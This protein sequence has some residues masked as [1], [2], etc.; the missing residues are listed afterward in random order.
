[1]TSSRPC[2]VMRTKLP[3]S[4]SAS[5]SRGSGSSSFLNSS[6]PS[7]SASSRRRR[8]A[9]RLRFSEFGSGTMSRSLVA[10]MWPCAP[11]AN[12]PI[13]MKPTFA[14]S[15]AVRSGSP[16]SGKVSVNCVPLERVRDLEP[17]ACPARGSGP[18]PVLRAARVSAR[19][20]RAAQSP[21][22]LSRRA[23]NC[24][25]ASFLAPRCDCRC[26]LGRSPPVGR[27]CAPAGGEQG[28]CGDRQGLS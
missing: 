15:R 13:T 8:F 27:I 6:M 12:P 25:F 24:R 1:M 20:I 26:V 19:G 14:S 9:S 7:T 5:G 18:W 21:A 10:R 3:P 23:S 11:T 22:P 16:S 28:G 4:A 2:F 17:Q